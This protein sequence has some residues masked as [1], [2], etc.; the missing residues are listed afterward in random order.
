MF[1]AILILFGVPTSPAADSDPKDEWRVDAPHGPTHDVTLELDEVTWSS[2]SVHGNTVAFDLLGDIWTVPL[3]GGDATQLTSGPAWDAQPVFSADGSRI[4]F[5]SDRGG[6]ENIWLMRADGSA[7]EV[8]T[9]EEDARCTHPVWDPAGEYL[10]YRRRTVDTRSI[11]VTE[12]WQRHWKGGAGVGLTKLADHPHAGE[13]WPDGPYIYFSSRHGRFD[14]D[15]SA[16]EGLWRIMRL[17]RRTG[18][19]RP[20]AYGA[21]S[22]ARP[23]LSPDRAHLYFISRLRDR[24]VLERLELASGDRGIVHESLSPDEMEG[25]ALHGTYPRMAWSSAGELVFWA[26]GHLWRM[27]PGRAPIQIPFRAR[28]THTLHDIRRPTLELE[29][30]VRARVIR[31]PR[32][33]GRGEWAFSAMGALWVRDVGGAVRRISRGT[34]YAPAWSPDGSRLAWTSWS[35]SDGGRLHVTDRRGRGPVLPVRGQLTN[36]SWAEDGR[37]LVVLRGVGGNLSPDLASEPWYEAVLVR[38]QGRR[39]ISRVIT[40]VDARWGARKQLLRLHDDRLYFLDFD[41]EPRKPETATLVSVALDGTDRQAHLEL[42]GAVEAAISPDFRHVAY[43]RDHQLWVAALPPFARGVE[44]DAVPHAMVTKV[45]GDWV[46]WT[47]DSAEVTW[48]EGPVLKRRAVADLF[49]DKPEGDETPVDALAE[50]PA[51]VSLEL[52]LTVPRARP[53]GAILIDGARVIPM[54]GEPVLESADVLVVGDRIE[55]VGPSL[56]PPAGARVLDGTGLTV[57]PGLIDVHAHLHFAAGDIHPEQEWRYQV[58]LDYGVTTVQDPSTITDLVFTNRERV[59]AGFMRGPR[60][61]S[62]GQVL[63]GALSNTGAATP[64]LDAARA[65][66]R[67]LRAVGATS[68]KVY[69]QSQRTRRQWYRQV[70]VEEGV[71]CVPEGGGDLFMDLGMVLDGYPTMEHALPTAPLHRDVI[72]LWAASTGGEEGDGLGTFYTPTLQV[73]YGGLSGEN[74]FIQRD[75]PVDD[76]WLRRNSPHRLLEAKLWRH[77]MMGHPDDWRYQQTARDAAAIRAAGGHVT[78]GAHGELQGLG[79]HWELWAMGGPGALS[80]HDALRAATIEGARYIGIDHL[81]GSVEPGKLA[82]L[83]VVEGDPLQ[84]L[85]ASARIAFVIKNGEVVTE[86]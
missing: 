47:T 39:W 20:I 27:T 84:D 44:L 81:V 48:A 16:V 9:T 30:D 80:A 15:Q 31:W 14:Y 18:E 65:H 68:V 35:D 51:V 71:V 58:A 29:D 25:F 53:S 66:V 40:G 11:G 21:G 41:A 70:C 82:D 7:P 79:V 34:G 10:L 55:A 45:V 32:R 54:S 17:D 12:I 85:E 5:T 49:D 67:R 72:E 6:N 4:A 52:T 33:S 64:T 1:T 83:L 19:L 22:A 28:A 62:T 63:Y 61:F 69:Q 42:G 8:F 60:V 56:T 37:S 77:S 78:V 46:G 75:F 73:A 13:M 74:Y 43:K 76:P 57:L 59:A 36:P 86:R 50:D 26:D 38:R 24:T 2:V 23:T 3:A